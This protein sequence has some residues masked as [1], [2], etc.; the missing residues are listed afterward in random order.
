MNTLFLNTIMLILIVGFGVFRLTKE[1]PEKRSQIL[2]E[3][4]NVPTNFYKNCKIVIEKAK[5]KEL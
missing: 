5:K 2:K 4:K 3:L 1:T